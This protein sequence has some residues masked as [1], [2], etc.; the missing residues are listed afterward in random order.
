[1]ET[2]EKTNHFW[3]VVI[4]SNELKECASH[5]KESNS[6][7][8][9]ALNFSDIVPKLADCLISWYKDHDKHAKNLYIETLKFYVIQIDD[10]LTMNEEIK[11]ILLKL[12]KIDRTLAK[13]E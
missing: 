7:V 1:M 3:S 12:D 8:Q 6:Q 11:R 10:I 5:K 13:F 4:R 2:M 9:D